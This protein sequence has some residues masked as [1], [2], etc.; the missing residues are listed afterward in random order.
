[1]LLEKRLRLGNRVLESSVVGNNEH[2]SLKISK[3]VAEV[4]NEPLARKC[5]GGR[6]GAFSAE[7]RAAEDVWN[8]C[9]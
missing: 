8:T 9:G 4:A 1:M 3:P 5:F 2:E 7:H 6:G